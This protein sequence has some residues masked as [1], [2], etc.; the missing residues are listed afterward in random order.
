MTDHIQKAS[1]W[2]IILVASPVIIGAL[3]N[4]A[5]NPQLFESNVTAFWVAD[6]F[7]HLI[8]PVLVLYLLC[9]FFNIKP[10]DYGLFKPGAG[11]PAW[12]MIGA[13]IFAAVILIIISTVFWFA[14]LLI[15]GNQD[16][17]FAFNLVVPDNA[18]HFL[19]VVYLALTAGVIEEIFYRGL[20]WKVASGI[21]RVRLR[22]FIYV[23]FGSIIFSSL[24]WEQGFA[25]LL[26]TFAFGVAAALF[27]LQLKNLWPMIGAH[28]LVDVYYFW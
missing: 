4:V 22:K 16:F 2:Y 27:Y 28:T 26:S 1:T 3:V 9:K 6:T 18:Y 11:Y 20:A 19:V 7:Q 5:Y 13:S 17:I 24:H 10:K 14:G 21:N 12:E 8:L 25:G 23:V 15:F